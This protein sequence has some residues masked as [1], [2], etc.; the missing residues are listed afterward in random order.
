MNAALNHPGSHRHRATAPPGERGSS[1]WPML[2]R[3]VLVALFAAVGFILAGPVTDASAAPP[4]PSPTAGVPDDEPARPGIVSRAQWR[5]LEHFAESV[6]D[7]HDPDFKKKLRS[8]I[9]AKRFIEVVGKGGS[10]SWGNLWNLVQDV[11]EYTRRSKMTLEGWK[12]QVAETGDKIHAQK[13][14]VK[15]AKTPAERQREEEELQKLVNQNNYA[16][17]ELRKIKAT[18]PLDTKTQIKNLDADIKKLQNKIRDLEQ[19][20]K[21]HRLPAG[22]Q[23]VLDQIPELLEQLEQARTERDRLRGGPDDD[24]D[25]TGGARP[26]RPGPKNPPGGPGADAGKPVPAGPLTS[27]TKTPTAGPAT[28]PAVPGAKLPRFKA[29]NGRGAG[30]QAAG[31]LLGQAYAEWQNRQHQELLEKARQDPALR[32]RIIDEYRAFRDSNPVKN[33]ARAFT[34]PE[35]SPGALYAAGPTL[36]ELQQILDTTSAKAA[37]SNADPLYQQAR[38]KCGGY[39]T[40]VTDRV[41]KLRAQKKATTAKTTTGT[42]QHKQPQKKT[43][44]PDYRGKGGVKASAA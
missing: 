23:Q 16:S 17:G 44:T 1:H 25:G 26:T 38:T 18:L 8:Q 6:L 36:T 39:D 27:G 9:A 31:E 19:K 20:A 13:Q 40:C 28:G 15:D 10:I 21:K 32:A 43:Q 30:S 14:R 29:F 7:P 34:G 33:I 2:L 5:I 42:G 41:A 35:L 12:K 4:P 11:E 24:S 3:M 22:R 37:D